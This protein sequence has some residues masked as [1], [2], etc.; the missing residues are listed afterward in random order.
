MSYKKTQKGNLRNKINE[1]K[2]YLTKEIGILKKN[3]TEILQLKNSKN[4]M[5]NALGCTGNK[6]GHM[7]EN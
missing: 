4:E 2:E 7:E 6:A 3:Q 5:K 1:Q